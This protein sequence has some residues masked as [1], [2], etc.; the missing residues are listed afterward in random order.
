MHKTTRKAALEKLDAMDALIA[1]SDDRKIDEYYADLEIHPGSFIGDY[2][3]INKFLL[4]DH[5]EQLKKSTG[6]NDWTKEANVAV[7]N[8]YYAF[9]KNNIILPASILRGH[10]FQSDLPKY[11]TYGSTGYVIVHEIIHGFDSVGSNYDEGGNIVE[12][13]EEKTKNKFNENAQCMIEQY[14]NYPVEQVG[15]KARGDKC[16][17]ENIADNG[18][19]KSA[20]YAYQQW[21][22]NSNVKEPCLPNL[23]YTPQQ[24]FWISAVNVWCTKVKDD[25]LQRMVQNDVHSPNIARVSITFSNMKEFARDFQCKVGSKMNPTNRCSVW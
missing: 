10:F 1:Y 5:Y 11:V 3:T 18:G 20:Y 12:W 14:N 4:K 25:V 23:D 8:A 2:L 22:K 6:D 7:I 24:M 13:W 19:I 9:S 16:I 21:V 15:E 17:T